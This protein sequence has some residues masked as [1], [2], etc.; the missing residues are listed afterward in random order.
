MCE[1]CIHS[2][3]VEETEYIEESEYNISCTKGKAE[4]TYDKIRNAIT[5]PEIK[6]AYLERAKY[7]RWLLSEYDKQI[8]DI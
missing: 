4:Q 7:L 8:Q 2:I 3:L 6:V 1:L 5:A